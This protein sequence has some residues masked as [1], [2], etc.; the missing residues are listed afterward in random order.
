MICLGKCD[1]VQCEFMGVTNEPLGGS[2]STQR[3]QHVL[4]GGT[5]DIKPPSDA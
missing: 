2:R 3:L 5:R 4:M 1:G